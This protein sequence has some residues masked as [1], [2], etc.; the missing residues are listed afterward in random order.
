MITIT[1]P[2]RDTDLLRFRVRRL[3]SSKLR[4]YEILLPLQFNDGR[5][6]PTELLAEADLEIVDKFDAASYET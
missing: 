5:D 4:R 2:D 1:F 6:V 3:M